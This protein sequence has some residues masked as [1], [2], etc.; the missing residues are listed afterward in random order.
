[1]LFS[2]RARIAADA[3]LVRAMVDATVRGYQD[4]LANPTRSLDDLLS[5]NPSLKRQLAEASLRAYLPLFKGDAPSYGVL[6]SDRVS[7]LSAWLLRYHLIKRAI[8][9]ARYA[10]DA[11]LPSH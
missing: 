8:S 2:T 9:P 3:P 5:Q 4:T 10:T 1:M 6:R 11:F 7:Q